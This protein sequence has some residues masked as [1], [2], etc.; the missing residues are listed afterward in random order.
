MKSQIATSSWGGRRKLPRGFTEHGAVMLASVLSTPVAMLASVYVVRAFI[1]LRALVLTR[2]E[3]A[4]KLADIEKTVARHDDE[5]KAV[6]DTLRRLL[7]APSSQQ[8]GKIGF[9]HE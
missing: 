7:E 4:A 2:R 3:L 8:E 9:S 1:R 5:I 6:F